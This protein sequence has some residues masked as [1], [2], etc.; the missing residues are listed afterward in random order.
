[1]ENE[2]QSGKHRKL[3]EGKLALDFANTVDWHAS[4]HPQETLCS[5]GDLLTWGRKA[6][7]V[8]SN[9]ATA[10]RQEAGRQPERASAVLKEAYELREVVYRV[11]AAVARGAPPRRTDMTALNAALRRAL[12]HLVLVPGAAGFL[13][14]WHG[15]GG[16]LDRVLWPVVRSAAE[17]LTSEELDRVRQCADADCG[18]LFLDMSKNRSRRWCE[19]RSCGN[20]AKARRYYARHRATKQ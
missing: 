16:E 10:L 3:L 15:E 7:I 2:K 8:S 13:W 20:R 4:D 9:E 6:G 11:F 12:L 19:M 1:M 14:D 17:L 5:Y 18:W